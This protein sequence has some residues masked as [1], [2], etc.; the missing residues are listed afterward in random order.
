VFKEKN[1]AR[2]NW[3]ADERDADGNPVGKSNQPWK[4]KKTDLSVCE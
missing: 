3:L 1:E 4:K 2:Y